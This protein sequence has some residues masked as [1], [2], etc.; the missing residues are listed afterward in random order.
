M[1]GDQGDLFRA[2]V[3][4]LGRYT[5]VR[6][7]SNRREFDGVTG[8]EFSMPRETVPSTSR[9]D[10]L[11]SNILYPTLPCDSKIEDSKY[12]DAVASQQYR[13]FSTYDK[14]KIKMEDIPQWKPSDVKYQYSDP[15]ELRNTNNSILIVGSTLVVVCRGSNI[16]LYQRRHTAAGYPELYLTNTIC[17]QINETKISP[18][19]GFLCENESQLRV[20]TVANDDMYQVNLSGEYKGIVGMCP[21]RGIIGLLAW[22][23]ASAETDAFVGLSKDKLIRVANGRNLDE[24]KTYTGEKFTCVATIAGDR[25][26]AA[27]LMKRNN[28]GVLRLYHGS[29]ER[30][31][32]RR[33]FQS[34][35][36]HHICIAASGQWIVLT[37]D[38]EPIL[39]ETLEDRCRFQVKPKSHIHTLKLNKDD[40]RRCQ[41]DG[42]RVVF[43]G[44]YFH[45]N[46][47]EI[48]T[49]VGHFLVRWRLDTIEKCIQS[50]ED[51]FPYVPTWFEKDIIASGSSEGSKIVVVM[52]SK[53]VCYVI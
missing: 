30:A 34:K 49:T 2:F 48:V 38:G 14:V 15:D 45:N 18:S 36:I 11:G 20:W 28:T 12:A 42:K 1:I 22:S 27:S 4:Y 7:P 24:R 40:M 32:V 16:G 17:L 52:H 51:E 5:N 33:Y 3:Q 35:P 41:R 47:E 10:P 43:T 50:G 31:K 8:R 29:I 21:R 37:T 26:A 6:G 39:F 13:N 23:S 53:S 25:I 9:A 46:D 19:G 44:A